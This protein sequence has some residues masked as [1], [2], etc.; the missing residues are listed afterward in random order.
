MA[1]LL[2]QPLDT[3][4]ETAPAPVAVTASELLGVVQQ[5][6]TLLFANAETTDRT[7]AAGERVAAA[8]GTRMTIFPRWDALVAE[9]ESDDGH[10]SQIARVAPVG[11]DMNKVLEGERVIEGLAERRLTLREARAE[12]TR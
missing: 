1:S 7:V 5:G 10:R 3:P 11:I 2:A 6:T 9:L 12:F 4:E 8:L